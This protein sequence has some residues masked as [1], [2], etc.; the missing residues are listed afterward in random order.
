MSFALHHI[1]MRS[2]DV[3]RLA[4]FYRETFGFAVVREAPPRSVW[5]G[6]GGGAVLMSERR[7]DEETPPSAAS[8]ELIAFAVDESGREAVKARALANGCFDGETSFTVYLRDPEGRRLAVS[9][10]D[11]A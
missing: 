2:G 8:K 4:A 9:T 10:Y 6:L 3:A 7:E 11:L 1:A 5:L